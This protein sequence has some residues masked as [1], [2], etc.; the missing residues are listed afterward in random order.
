MHYQDDKP[1]SIDRSQEG[2][3][4]RIQY[5]Q[6]LYDE[7]INSLSRQ[8]QLFF[9]EIKDDEVFK[10]MQ[11][12]SL[13]QEF[14]LQ[15]AVELLNEIM[16]SEQE[17]TIHKLQNELIEYN[18]LNKKLEY[19]KQK[20]INAIKDIEERLRRAE[21][22]KEKIFT[23]TESQ[24]NESLKRKEI[25]FY[26]NSKKK[27]EIMQNEI[28]GLRNELK[29]QEIFSYR[30]LDDLKISYE[31]KIEEITQELIENQKDSE[32]LKVQFKNYQKQSE[33]LAANHQSVIK[34]LVD[35]SKQL[36]QKIISQKSKLTEYQR[37]SKEN[38]QSFQITR[39]NYEKTIMNLEEKIKSI[40][41][42]TTLK[43]ND[44]LHR[45][46]EQIAQLQIQYKNIMDMK[47]AEMQKEVD[48]QIARSQEHDR[49]VKNLMDM[50]M[51]EIDRDFIDLSSH[52]KI[53]AEKENLLTDTYEEK[54][55]EL[56]IINEDLQREV[57]IIN[58]ENEEFHMRIESLQKSEDSLKREILREKER[59]GSD[60]NSKLIKLKEVENL[61]YEISKELDKTKDILKK[62]KEDYDEETNN[63][64]K[65]EK[66]I[67]HLNSI[68]TDLKLSLNS[69]KQSLQGTKNQYE[70]ILLEK[71]DKKQY[72]QEKEKSQY[73]E[74]EIENKVLHISRLE[75]EINNLQGSLRES[76]IRC[77]GDINLLDLEQSRHTET[78]SQL[79]ELENYSQKLI[80]EIE[81]REVK[82]HELESILDNYKREIL[83]LELINENKDKEFF[84]YK[85]NAL[86]Q[87]AEIRLKYK[88][89]TEKT[90]KYLKNSVFFLKKQILGISELF[91]HEYSSINK[92]FSTAIQEISL[93]I[94][95]I[96]YKSRKEIDIK[97]EMYSSDIKLFYKSRLA[98]LEN[99]INSENIHWSDSDTEGIRRAV[100]SLIERKNIAQIE[101]KTLRESLNT[102]TGQNEA[103]YRENQKLQIRLH[104][105]NEAFDQLQ[106][107]VT[108]EANKI[109]NRLETTGNKER[110]DLS[111]RGNYYRG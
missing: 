52:E 46:Q 43:E 26:S 61:R 40:E 59:L 36:K 49:E 84:T 24:L 1:L 14:A 107:E 13:S 99:Y 12:N 16:K 65:S 81:I 104:A 58:K 37:L 20:M 74:Q 80:N 111:A 44:M 71:V 55:Q 47:L 33:E 106:R 83:N 28:N 101:I 66:E 48:I 64:L 57:N 6:D 102:L 5:I 17:N 91:E 21:I 68:I 35:K 25:E 82:Q 75:E 8:V 53:I 86:N 105:N 87:E 110:L 97:S 93:R 27:N 95:E 7:R 70:T 39:D 60:L 9:N 30:Q 88:A 42:E 92:S 38:S 4:G 100:K 90:K 18:T 51:K 2:S 22:E 29:N 73:L 108:E 69:I 56:K 31:A 50:K 89:F 94:I 54:N 41:K 79:K 19:E 15:R 72:F 63:K 98:Q 109:K 96:Q 10:A 62:T 103:L 78:R 85:Q 34:N 32:S 11:E 3:Y 76:K 23:H 45:Q 67:I 77:A